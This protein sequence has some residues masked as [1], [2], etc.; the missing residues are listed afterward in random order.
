M[1][2]Y[3]I[4]PVFGAGC[5]TSLL[6]LSAVFAPP[7]AAQARLT[8]SAS[9]SATGRVTTTPDGRAWATDADGNR[10]A[11]DVP[12]VVREPARS[13]DA[14]VPA[15][16]IHVPAEQPTI[17]AGINAA[18]NGDTVLVAPGTYVENINFMGKAIAVVSSGGSSATTIDGGLVNS[19]VRFVSGEGP[20]SLL[21]GF[22]LQNGRAAPLEGGGIFISSASPTIM[23]NVIKFNGACNGGGGIG[24]AFGSP[25]IRANVIMNNFQA[26]CSGGVGGGGIAV[27]GAGAAEI[28]GNI[29]Q[30]NNWNASGGGVSFFAAGHARLTNN[31]IRGNVPT[32][33]QGGGI[34]IVN[35][36]DAPLLQ[37]LFHGN[38]GSTGNAIYFSIPSGSVGPLL[39]NNTVIGAAGSAVFAGGF[40]FNVRFYNNV[41]VGA[42]GQTAVLCDAT[43]G[44]FSPT[45][46][47]NDA[48]SAGGQGLAG[49]CAAQ[50]NQNGNISMDP[51]FVNAAAANYRLTVGSPAVD[52]GTNSAPNL[53]PT[54]MENQPRIVDGDNNGTATIDMGSYEMPEGGYGSA[55]LEVEAR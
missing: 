49:T 26:G 24:V 20:G 53:P 33:G 11:L 18:V 8:V 21:R 22:T 17:Q 55:D 23:R 14:D 34:W 19:V 51:V 27:R 1:R 28:V 48:Y 46:T 2:I 25:L 15:A 39:V 6:A 7:A 9:G 54:D 42:P 36:H 45:F 41:V 50:G 13:T 16:V 10:V 4:A 35:D 43:F 52:A 47:A 32:S 29:I 3:S 30:N 38:Q 37:N 31:T 5:C 44:Q 12:A 40:D